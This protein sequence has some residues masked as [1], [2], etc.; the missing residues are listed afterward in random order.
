MTD[1]T[2]QN[3]TE[4]QVNTPATLARTKHTARDSEPKSIALPQADALKARFKAGSIPLQTDFADLI[5]LANMWRQAVGGAEGQTGPAD[6]FTLS[7]EGRLELK[8]NAAKGISVDKDGIAV[9]AEENKGLQVNNNGVSVK[10]G[11]GIQIDPN[12][13]SIKLAA[14]S[15]LSA[16]ETNGLK[17]APEQM[18]Q[19]GMVMMFAGTEAE[20]PKGWALCDGNGG[21]PDL[22]DR[23]VMGSTGFTNVNQTNGKKATGT[24]VD[25]QFMVN[26]D[27]KTPSVSVTVNNHTLTTSEIPSHHHYDG[28]RYN[29]DGGSYD[30]MNISEYGRYD[31]A[32]KGSAT[33]KYAKLE[34]HSDN[35]SYNLRLVESSKTGGSVGHNH[36]ASVT[37]SSHQHNTNV[38]PPYYILAFIIKL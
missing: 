11:N 28:V 14:N 2:Q 17:I 19:K 32:R 30:I 12:G 4:T 23:F 25:K 16:D 3:K 21:R 18:F 27:A 10:P 37:P 36:T 38:V 9:K 24:N 8:P 15:G 5:D 31:L 26:S 29:Y 20:M 7:S 6:G 22:R 34:N 35:T 13:V 1:K 33:T